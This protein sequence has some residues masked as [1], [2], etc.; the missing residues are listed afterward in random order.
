MNAISDEMAAKIIKKSLSKG[1]DYAD[2]FVEYKHN[3]SIQ[4]EDNKIEK[5]I[6]GN[7]SGIGIPS[8]SPR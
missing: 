3:S 4:L 1:G 2:I 8:Y 6:S 5:V 7:D